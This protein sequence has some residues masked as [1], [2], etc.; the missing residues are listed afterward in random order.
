MA[1]YLSL[2][3][4]DPWYGAVSRHNEGLPFPHCY[5]RKVEQ[6]YTS[7]GHADRLGGGFHRYLPS[8]GEISRQEELRFFVL[9]RQLERKNQ[10]DWKALEGS[11]ILYVVH[12]FRGQ[13]LDKEISQ[14]HLRRGVSP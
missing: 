14:R 13:T 3:A 6:P 5:F 11:I 10:G 9:P 8:H 7:Q 12:D 1:F 2:H 4:E